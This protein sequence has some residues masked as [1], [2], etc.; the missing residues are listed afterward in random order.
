MGTRRNKIVTSTGPSA[1][2]GV[3]ED[4]RGRSV[5]QW[6]DYRLDSTTVLLRKLEN[7]ALELEPTRKLRQPVPGGP[8]LAPARDAKAE[9]RPRPRLRDENERPTLSIEET[10][11]VKLGGGFDPY[12]RS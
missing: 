7:T 9:K 3:T 2:G 5:W 1:P 10:F 12:N 11:K 8:D 6:N 4:S